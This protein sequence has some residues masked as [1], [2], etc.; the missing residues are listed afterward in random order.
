MSRLIIVTVKMP[1]TY[2]EAIDE[3]LKRGRYMSR[4]EVIRAAVRKLIEEELWSI[5]KPVKTS[6]SKVEVKVV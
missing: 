4:S 6:S 3:L 1:E 5:Q 2:L